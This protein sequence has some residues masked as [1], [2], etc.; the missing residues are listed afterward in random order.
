MQRLGRLQRDTFVSLANRNYRLYFVGQGISMSGTWMQGVAQGLLV[1]DLTGS[2]T[3]LGLVTAL[4]TL[5]ILLFGAFGGVIADRFP[6][7]RL[8]YGTQ[9]ISA[10]IGLL[11]GALVFTGAIELWM[12]Y[13]LGV[14]S[15]LV[16]VVE[17]PTR[18]TFVRELVGTDNL[19]NA[20]SLNSTQIN[21]ARVI[22]PSLAGILVATVGLSWCFIVDGVSY[23]AVMFT[24]TRMRPAEMHVGQRAVPGHGQLLE[25]FRYVRSSRPIRTILVMMTIIGLFTYEF[26]VV[27]PLFAQFTLDAGATGYAALTA[28]M[29]AG[30][31]VGG[32]YS[33]NKRGSSAR[34]LVVA[35]AL[36]GAAVLLT[37]VAPTLT[38]A[39]LGMV[40]VGFTSI[41]FTALGNV[42]LQTTSAPQM[43]GRVMA[44]WTVSF[45]GTTPI[46]GPLMGFVGQNAGARVAL[47][48]GGIAAIVAAGV[49]A[50]SLL[51]RGEPKLGTLEGEARQA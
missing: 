50:W 20:I 47:A 23:A 28:A 3:A 42:T 25:G 44:L 2:G 11:T 31:V 4:Q 5:P 46:G 43:Q 9:V 45:L 13:A 36:F 22:G 40:L 1:L 6:K 14:V 34:S 41:Q 10:A 37:S 17:N 29:G 19:R 8:L 51:G 16:K 49:G 39:V 26:S 24:M 12:V 27:L 38:F 48:I 30:A 32:L 21:L 35:A 7:M 18:Q 33:A 15:G